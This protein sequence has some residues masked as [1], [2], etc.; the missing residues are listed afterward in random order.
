MELLRRV[1]EDEVAETYVRAELA[2]ERFRE[3]IL[4]RTRGWRIGGLFHGFPDELEWHRAALSPDEVLDILCL[5]WHWW[6]K[7]SAARAHRGE[8]ADGPLVLVEAPCA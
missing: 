2:S 3:Q 5:D 1:P 8:D 6:L 7:I 4:A